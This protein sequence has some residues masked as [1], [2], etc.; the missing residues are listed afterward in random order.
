MLFPPKIDVFL[1][2]PRLGPDRSVKAL[3]TYHFWQHMGQWLFCH[4]SDTRHASGNHGYTSW[5]D[6]VLL[7]P[8]I[9]YQC[10]SCFDS[11][12]SHSMREWSEVDEGLTYQQFERSSVSSYSFIYLMIRIDCSL[13]LTEDDTRTILRMMVTLFPELPHSWLKQS[14]KACHYR[15]CVVPSM[16][17]LSSHHPR[18]F[19]DFSIFHQGQARCKPG[20]QLR[21]LQSQPSFFLRFYTSF[22]HFY[23]NYKPMSL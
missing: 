6:A 14:I 10:I 7:E 16:M 11:K 17:Y 20:Y 22:S 15:P 19:P 9:R 1:F 3:G 13:D 4:A 8:R 12:I 2:A 18:L 23:D 5:E 21:D